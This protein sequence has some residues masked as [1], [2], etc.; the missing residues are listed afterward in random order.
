MTF[1]NAIPELFNV[2]G[3]LFLCLYLY[4]VMGVYLFANVRLQTNLNEYANFQTF[5]QSFLLLLRMSTGEGWNDIMED[6]ARQRTIH[7][8]CNEN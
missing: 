2:G 1:L 6:S 7:F 4:A 3:V 5:F 8:M